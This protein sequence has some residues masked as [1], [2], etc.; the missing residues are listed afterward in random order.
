[1]VLLSMLHTSRFAGGIAEMNTESSIRSNI[2][3]IAHRGASFDAPEN[4]LTAVQLGWRQQ[5]DAVEIDV[6]LTS[7][8][9]IVVIHDDTTLRYGGRDKPV[10]E[11]SLAELRQIDVGL[12]KGDQWAGERIPT[13]TEVLE[14]IPDGKRLFVEIKCGDEIVPALSRC[15]HPR[16]CPK[17]VVLIGL[18]LATMEAVKQAL[19]QFEVCWVF[20]PTHCREAWTA[21][22]VIA[23]TKSAGLDGLDFGADPRIDEP[24]LS[25]VEQ[26][27]LSAYVWTV[28]DVSEAVRLREAGIQGIT[29]DRPSWLRERLADEDSRAE[30]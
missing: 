10:G 4:T 16:F 12:W 27:G 24:L 11:E 14:T 29:T 20:S 26:A 30:G 2:E 17:Q 25:A 6:R 18:H 7:D 19:P 23:R 15:V 28:N 3:I 22:D 1:M 21:Q 13:L 5:A 9:E 8:G